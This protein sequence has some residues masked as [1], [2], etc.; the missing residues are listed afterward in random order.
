VGQLHFSPD[1]KALLRRPGSSFG[2]GAP[3]R[4]WNAATGK[5]RQKV[6]IPAEKVWAVAFGGGEDRLHIAAGKTVQVWPASKSSAFRVEAEPDFRLGFA[7][8]SA[9]GRRLAISVWAKKFMAGESYKREKIRVIDTVSG[10]M[11][12]TVKDMEGEPF[13]VQL[14]SDGKRLLV[15]LG[16]VPNS[17]GDKVVVWDVDKKKRVTVCLLTSAPVAFSSDGKLVAHVDSWG[18]KERVLKVSKVPDSDDE[19]K[20]NEVMKRAFQDVI[21][22]NVRFTPDGRHLIFGIGDSKKK[23]LSKGSALHILDLQTGQDLPVD[24]EPLPTDVNMFPISPDGTLLA[25]FEGAGFPGGT[26][27]NPRDIVVRDLTGKVK[28]KFSLIGHTMPVIGVAVSPDGQRLASIA[29]GGMKPTGLWS[30]A[31]IKLWDLQNGQEVLHLTVPNEIVM[32]RGPFHFSADGHRLYLLGSAKY[33]DDYELY[34]WDATP[35]P[36]PRP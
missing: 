28:L 16:P 20:D 13:H 27:K 5:V 15:H 24:A 21:P 3:V 31:E 9:N 6:L 8:L 23:N 19:S 34:T 33:E 7:S 4:V 2:T 18:E 35:L 12:L 17:N 25:G 30:A 22:N 14:S 10:E 29:T 26:G 32:P 36:G 1:G 11:L